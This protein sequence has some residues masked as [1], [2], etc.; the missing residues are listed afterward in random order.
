MVDAKDFF[1]RKDIDRI[2]HDM[3]RLRFH[4]NTDI[5][6]VLNK[7]VNTLGTYM[8]SGLLRDWPGVS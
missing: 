2:F 1:I 5:K 4:L 8:Y 3:S 7:R 6:Q